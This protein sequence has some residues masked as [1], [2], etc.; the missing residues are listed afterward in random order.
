[1][2]N[3]YKKHLFFCL[4][5]KKDGSGCGPLSSEEEFDKVKKQYSK[6]KD[7]Y[8]LTKTA[9]LGKCEVGP[10]AVVYPKGTWYSYKEFSDIA[11]IV[12]SEIE[13][14]GDVS[15]LEL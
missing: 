2:Q 14:K 7:H 8:R 11:R 1:M 3:N 15:D 4:N 10:V 13:G 5:L 9:C 6:Y 12:A